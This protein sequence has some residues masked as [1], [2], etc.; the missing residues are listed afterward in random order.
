MRLDEWILPAIIGL[1]LKCFQAKA[2]KQGMRSIP[3]NFL[4]F[5]VLNPANF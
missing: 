4:V 3:P 5:D 1:K 2:N